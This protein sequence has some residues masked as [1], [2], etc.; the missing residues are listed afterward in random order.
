LAAG[1]W[2]PFGLI[3]L[4]KEQAPDDEASVLLDLPPLDDRLELLGAPVVELALSCDRPHGMVAVRLCDV[5]PDGVSAR[6]TY[7]LLDLGFRDGFE[8]R[9]PLEPG[10]RYLVR[11]PLLHCGHAFPAGHRIRVAVSSSYWPVVWPSAER[12]SLTLHPGDSRVLLPE[13]PPRARDDVLLPFPRAEVGPSPA[14]EVDDGPPPTRV[15][16]RDAR[17]GEVTVEVRQGWGP[18]GEPL[19]LPIEPIGLESGWAIEERFGVR[20]D[21]PASA[22]AEIRHV[23]T[24]TRPGWSARL[25]VRVTQCGMAGGQRIRAEVAA[26][27]NGSELLRRVMEEEILTG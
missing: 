13:R 18:D 7:G 15:V 25:E 22:W 16:R 21:E 4:P 24:S 20:P 2:C 19:L 14:F 9:V 8:E 1:G 27:E 6:V 5:A 12:C 23:V 3:D 26:W 11:I 17:T 10:R